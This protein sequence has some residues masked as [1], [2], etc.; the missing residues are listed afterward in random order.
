MSFVGRAILRFFFPALTAG[1]FI[2]AGL[3]ALGAYLFF[4]YVCLPFR[5]QGA[6][7]EPAYRDGAFHF[8]WRGRYLLSE[9]KRYEVVGIRFAGPQVMLLKRIVALEGEEV[10]FR[11][12]NLYVNGEEIEEPYVR[13]KRDWNLSPRRVEK[14]TS[15]SLETTGA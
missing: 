2:R 9:P 3:V 6:S 10:E 5:I 7:M 15:L 14:G 4:G 12:G 8:C 13:F 1:F 11:G